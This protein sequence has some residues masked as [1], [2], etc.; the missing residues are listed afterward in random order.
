MSPIEIGAQAPLIPGVDLDA[1]PTAV[2]FY[3]VT[4]PV[5]QMAAPKVS[6]LEAAFPG[7]VV[8]VGQDPADA[9]EAFDD[10]F[11]FG[12]PTTSDTPPYPASDAYAIESVPTLVLVGEDGVVADV[13]QSW[14][15]DGYNR[16]AA[17]LAELTGRPP[18]VV[19]APD[20]GLPPF[21]PG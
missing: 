15:R 20:D 16:V 6:M 11:D 4:C 21:R 3:K 1:G 8:G 7:R 10:R 19:S 9:L 13:V 2:V 18:V 17:E 5:C 12:A 14:D